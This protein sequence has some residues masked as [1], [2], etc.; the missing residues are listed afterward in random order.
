MSKSLVKYVF[1]FTAIFLGLN[2]LNVSSAFSDMGT[3][4]WAFEIVN[5]MYE[6]G[7][8]SG[9]EDNTFRPQE[10]VTREQFASILVK[11]LNLDTATNSVKFEDVEDNIHHL[12]KFFF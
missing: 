9:F 7:I 8:I 1:I 3:E 4:H 2:S 6:K 5:S 12:Q 11:I 10:Y